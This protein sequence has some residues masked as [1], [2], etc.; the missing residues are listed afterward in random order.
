MNRLERIELIES[1]EE[2][3]A[4]HEERVNYYRAWAKLEKLN[5]ST[6]GFVLNDDT[7]T[8]YHTNETVISDIN[9]VQENEI[10]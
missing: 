7:A 4:F 9:T 8:N 6:I 10:F 3:I 5:L 2:F 1:L